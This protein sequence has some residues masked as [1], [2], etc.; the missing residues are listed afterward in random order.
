MHDV[1]AV[2]VVQRLQDLLEYL[3]S[4]VLA[5]VLS[6]DD[7]VEKLSTSAQLSDKIHIIIVLEVLVKFD[8]VWMILNKHSHS[9]ERELMGYLLVSEGS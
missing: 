7:S 8:H 6:F 3:G 1:H 4:H 9:L 5:E 2:T